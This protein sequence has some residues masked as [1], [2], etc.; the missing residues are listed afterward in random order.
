MTDD[1]D[2]DGEFRTV[3]KTDLRRD[4]KFRSQLFILVCKSEKIATVRI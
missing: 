4:G 1:Y 3:S 2:D